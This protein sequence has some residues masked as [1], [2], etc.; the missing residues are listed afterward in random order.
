MVRFPVSASWETI[1]NPRLAFQQWNRD[2]S[3]KKKKKLKDS[4][5][6]MSLKSDSI[7]WNL[8]QKE[9][10]RRDSTTWFGIWNFQTPSWRQYLQMHLLT[11]RFFFGV[12]IGVFWKSESMPSKYRLTSQ[13]FFFFVVFTSIVYDTY[14]FVCNHLLRSWRA[15]GNHEIRERN[16]HGSARVSIANKSRPR[17]C[18]PWR[19]MVDQ[20]MHLHGP[21]VDVVRIIIIKL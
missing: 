13:L 1:S 9:A 15:G 12:K 7:R 2:W 8:F 20:K 5:V 10:R 16:H 6:W 3:K 18:E 21:C 4:L 11:E 17:N 14:G 19:L